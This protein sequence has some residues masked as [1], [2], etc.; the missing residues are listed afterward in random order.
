MKYYLP[1]D[2][3]FGIKGG[4]WGKEQ[5]VLSNSYLSSSQGGSADTHV[6]GSFCPKYTGLYT[7]YFN[8]NFEAKE[9]HVY[10]FITNEQKIL[11]GQIKVK[12]YSGECYYVYIYA[13]GHSST[14]SSFS[15][16]YE[17]GEI[18][19]T[20]SG[21]ELITCQYNGCINGGDPKHHCLNFNTYQQNH[22][23]SLQ[24]TLFFIIL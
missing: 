20:P 23:L 15:V 17:D 21:T 16:K 8:G 1:T 11:N 6:I 18:S 2:C 24:T 12:L 10:S 13:A 5:S 14:Y 4:I 3:S 22:F 7:L 19:Y 9:L